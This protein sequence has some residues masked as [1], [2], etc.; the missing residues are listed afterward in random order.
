MLETATERLEEDTSDIEEKLSTIRDEMKGL[1]VQLYARF[2][3]QINLE[4]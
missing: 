4:T 3:K 2:G 1:K